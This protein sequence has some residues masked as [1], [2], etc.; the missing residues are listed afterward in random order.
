MSLDLPIDNSLIL[1]SSLLPLSI[2]L[3]F[4]LSGY[5]HFLFNPTQLWFPQ[6]LIP[7]LPKWL[8]DYSQTIFV[9]SSLYVTTLLISYL[10]KLSSS[11][12]SHDYI[13]RR[14]HLALLLQAST[15]VFFFPWPNARNY[16]CMLSF[17]SHM[18]QLTNS[19]SWQFPYSKSCL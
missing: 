16:W 5:R 12:I 6:P 18:I 9:V 4:H 13:I 7:H 11:S 17:D 10:N 3:Y 19:F 8:V 15:K 14:S 2:S 1:T